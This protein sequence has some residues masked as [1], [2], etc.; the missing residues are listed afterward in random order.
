MEIHANEELYVESQKRALNHTSSNSCTISTSLKLKKRF[1]S[2]NKIGNQKKIKLDKE[3]AET[4][5]S[6]T[7]IEIFDDKKTK[8]TIV[9]KK[10]QKQ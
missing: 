10:T 2:K 7:I 9:E 8:N 6:E 4:I 1:N 3:I 5:K